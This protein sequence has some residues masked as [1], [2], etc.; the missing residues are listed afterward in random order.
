[1][2]EVDLK[3]K[4]GGKS[5]CACAAGGGGG[6]REWEEVQACR[7]FHHVDSMVGWAASCGMH[8][9]DHVLVWQVMSPPFLE[10]MSPEE[11]VSHEGA[12]LH[13]G[14]V[15]LGQGWDVGCCEKGPGGQWLIG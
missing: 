7:N 6:W 11:T 1:M 10:D 2:P 12:H 13:D 14:G 4:V 5:C 8:V 9:K 3:N 15:L